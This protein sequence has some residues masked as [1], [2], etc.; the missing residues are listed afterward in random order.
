[1]KWGC[2]VILI[3]NSKEEIEFQESVLKEI[4]KEYGGLSIEATEAPTI[5]P[6]MVMNF[7]RVSAIP[8]VFRAGGLFSTALQRNEAWDVQMDWAD[9]GEAIKRPWIEK[10]QLI[11]D[12]ADNPFMVLYENNCWGHCEEIFQYKAN[13]PKHLEALEPLFFEF[14]VAAMEMCMEPLSACDSRLRAIISP[15]MGHYNEWQKKISK[16]LDGNRV[17]DTGMYC[18]EIDFDLSKIDPGELRKLEK[19]QR[20]FT[21]TEEGPPA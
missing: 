3:G 19:L 16:A 7:L 5:G 11:D 17:A 21:W 4:I 12:L 13:D 14:S 6:M 18:D 15:M 1:V 9:K 2:T 20:E 8:M 10:N